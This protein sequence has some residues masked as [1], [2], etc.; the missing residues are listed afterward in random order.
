LP[1]YANTGLTQSLAPWYGSA[2]IELSTDSGLNW[3]N[4]GLARGVSFVE[5]IENAAIQ[6]DNGPDLAEYV[7]D[8]TVNITFNSLE[9]Y[10]PTLDKIRGGIDTLSVT[11]GGVATTDTDVYSTGATSADRI[12]FLANQGS[13][14][15][16]AAITDVTQVDTGNTSSTLTVDDD[17]TVFTNSDNHVGITLLNT[18]GSSYKS[19]ESVRIKYVY[20]SVPAYKLS[21]GGLSTI[22]SRWFRLTNIEIVSGS[23]KNRK[24]TIYSGSLNAGLNMALK[25]SNDADPVLENP[26]S[27]IGKI[28]STRTAGDQLFVIEDEKATA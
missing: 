23:N 21:S 24:I 28:D 12:Y 1:T 7:A 15:T 14:S 25:S 8:H 13:S 9:F 10:L 3:T 6:A 2:K 18:V 16:I 26:I 19:T 11:T 22:S 5:T 20:G 4:V 27:I 17:Y